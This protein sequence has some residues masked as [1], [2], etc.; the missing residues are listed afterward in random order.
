MTEITDEQKL[1]MLQLIIDELQCSRSFPEKLK[2]F[3]EDWKGVDI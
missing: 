2:E 1:K 3:L